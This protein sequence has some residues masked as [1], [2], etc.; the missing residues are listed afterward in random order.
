MRTEAKDEVVHD[1]WL[2]WNEGR[3]SR[4][5]KHIDRLRF[6][7]GWAVGGTPA[8][9]Q[10]S[11]SARRQQVC[12]PHPQLSAVPELICSSSGSK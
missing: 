12:V 10:F 6:K 7:A 9:L 1:E 3:R 2:S 4:F 8:G 5:R 11:P